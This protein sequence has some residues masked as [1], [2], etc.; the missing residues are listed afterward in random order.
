LEKRIDM[1]GSFQTCLRRTERLQARRGVRHTVP[2]ATASL[3]AATKSVA[4]SVGFQPPTAVRK[5]SL[6]T[7]DDRPFLRHRV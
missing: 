6:P 5:R 7:N 1:S 2:T 3:P 4:A